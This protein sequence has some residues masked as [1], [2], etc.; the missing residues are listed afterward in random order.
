VPRNQVEHERKI[1]IT[2]VGISW[3]LVSVA[4]FFDI[5]FDQFPVPFESTDHNLQSIS[6][7]LDFFL[8]LGLLWLYSKQKSATETQAKLMKA[9]NQPRVQISKRDHKKSDEYPDHDSI[10]LNE[11]Q[12]LLSNI[13]GGS[14]ENLKL[15]L[16]LEFPDNSNYS[17]G[18]RIND[19]KRIESS[20]H[21]DSD[22]PYILE[23]NET[24]WFRSEAVF[25]YSSPS[26]ESEINDAPGLIQLAAEENMSH[27]KFKYK[28]TWG[29]EFGEDK[30]AFE[31]PYEISW[32][33]AYG[34][35]KDNV[36]SR[37]RRRFSFGVELLEGIT[38]ENN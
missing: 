23:P 32:S 34:A 24:T 2:L 21:Y 17:G 33:I 22:W 6:I 28:I 7:I 25:E 12:F 19:L 13:G 18:V 14:A 16:E 10:Y 35:N 29:D 27:V 15:Q 31:N 36:E 26:G 20:D 11:Y 3:I 9:E 38:T 8:T 1:I 4:V 37:F 5:L 30:N